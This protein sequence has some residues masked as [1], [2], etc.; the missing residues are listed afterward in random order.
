M[1]N[2]ENGKGG[3]GEGGLILLLCFL[4]FG[5][6]PAVEANHLAVIRKGAQTVS[7]RI[8]LN[9]ARKN[10]A[11]Q[12]LSFPRRIKKEIW[13]TRGEKRCKMHVNKCSMLL[14]IIFLMG[15]V[16]YFIFRLSRKF[17]VQ[18]ATTDHVN[19]CLFVYVFYLQKVDFKTV[20]LI[21]LLFVDTP[22]WKRLCCCLAQEP[23][24]RFDWI[25]QWIIQTVYAATFP[26]G[27]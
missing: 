10:V 17:M 3:S 6:C 22:L 21:N 14:K 26:M 5:T 18:G 9:R 2:R 11:R 25:R 13:L 12:I 20:L 27:T 16:T 8:E 19:L 1:V 24:C 23:V 15:Q 7:G 4:A